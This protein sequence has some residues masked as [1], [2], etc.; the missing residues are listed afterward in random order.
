MLRA[1]RRERRVPDLPARGHA[2]DRR[3]RGAAAP[4]DPRRGRPAGDRAGHHPGAGPR[5]RAHHRARASFGRFT[6]HAAD[7]EASA[8]GL[9]AG[10]FI[11]NPFTDVPELLTSVFVTTDADPDRAAPRGARPGRRLLGRS[12]R[13]MVTAARLARR[14]GR[15]GA[16]R[17]PTGTIILTDAADATSSGAT[18]DS[19]AI[20]ART[21][22]GRLPRDGPRARSSMRRRSRRRS[23]PAWARPFG[24]PSAAGSIRRASRRCRSRARST[25][26]SDGLFASESDGLEW[27]AGATAVLKNEY[28]DDRRDEPAGHAL[29]PVAVPRLRP[30]PTA[31]STPSSSSRRTAS[32]AC[33]IDWAARTVHIDAPGSTSAN[34]R[35]LGHTRC[36]RPIFPLDDEVPF[37]PV[38]ELFSRPRYGVLPAR[39]AIPTR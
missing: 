34:L 19:N 10:I 28:A 21:R 31:R 36:P 24:R 14:G 3:P 13:R 22:D 8:G 23:R 18:G 4:P 17:R 7:I 37:A 39:R 25:C 32:R 5:R 29:R 12:T 38:V 15:G 35:S 30:G 2:L 26:S 20:L 33:S 16:R 1:R 27:S 9:S 6:H 11:S